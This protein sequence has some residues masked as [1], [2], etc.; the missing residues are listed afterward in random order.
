MRRLLWLAPIALAACTGSDTDTD[1]TGPIVSGPPTFESLIDSQTAPIGD[2]SGYTPGTPW[3][4]QAVDSAK[5]TAFPANVAVLDFQ[6]D[7][8]VTEATIEFWSADAVAGAP[9]ATGLTDLSGKTSLPAVTACQAYTYK[10]WT[11]PGR[12]ETVDTFEAHQIDPFPTAGVIETEFNS[13]SDSTYKIIPSL[14][15]VEVQPG[16]GV[17]AGTAYDSV[18]AKIQHAEVLV[19]DGTGVATGIP[20]SLVVKYFVDDFPNRDQPDTSEDGLWTAINVPPGDWTVEMYVWNG[21]EH[22]LVGATVLTVK[23]DSIN[24]SNIYTG[25]GD[26]VK[27]PAACLVEG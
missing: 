27:Y 1:D 2:L 3:L 11:D 24:I 16:F 12:E 9:D 15:G 23:P 7:T 5:K 22:V 20:E 25:F 14:L 17:I 19:H 21:T 26:G 8:P 4:T 10:T 13:V 6:E 18:G